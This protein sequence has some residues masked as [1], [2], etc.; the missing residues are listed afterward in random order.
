MQLAL[1]QQSQAFEQSVPVPFELATGRFLA[2]TKSLSLLSPPSIHG[3]SVWWTIQSQGAENDATANFFMPA[4][5]FPLFQ[6]TS[7]QSHCTGRRRPT[8]EPRCEVA[9]EQRLWKVCKE[10]AS[11][12]FG[13]SEWIIFLFF[14]V[15]A[16]AA[17]VYSFSELFHLLGSGS[18]E[19]TGEALLTR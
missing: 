11:L 18:V 14:G 2:G 8:A 10:T 16:I 4:H 13:T 9:P 3:D 15:V 12:N 7:E 17:T 6:R 19:H 1:W 5:R